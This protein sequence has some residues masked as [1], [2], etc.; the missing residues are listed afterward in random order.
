MPCGSSIG[1]PGWDG[2]LTVPCGNAWIPSGE[3]AL[4]MSCEQRPGPK[5]TKDYEKRT[6]DPLGA[7]IPNTTFVFVTPRR[8]QGKRDWAN[9]RKREGRW[10]DVRVLDAVDLVSWIEQAPKAGEWFDG[11]TG[12]DVLSR[13][14]LLEIKDHQESLHTIS[15][16]EITQHTDDRHSEVMAAIRG[17]GAPLMASAD[18]AEPQA[19]SDPAHVELKAK[20]DSARDSIRRGYVNVARIQLKELR[21]KHDT[22]S[23][24]LEFRILNSLGVCALVDE[25][26]DGACALFDEARRL[27][28]ENPKGI[29][30]AALVAHLRKDRQQAV[31]LAIKARELDPQISQATAVLLREY[32]ETERIEELEKL[33]TSEEWLAQDQHCGAVVSGIRVEQMRFGE[34]AKIC[35]SLIEADPGD[36]ELQLALAECLLS[37]VKAEDLAF[38]YTCDSRALLLEAKTAATRSIELL[39]DT[40]LKAEHR[41]ALVSRAGAEVLLGETV[42]ASQDLDKILLEDPAHVEASFYK[43]LLLV[44][45]GKPAEARPLFDCVWKSGRY[46]DVVLPLADACIAS[47]DPSASVKLL[48]GTITLKCP[49]WMDIDRAEILSQAEKEAGVEGS[50]EKILNAAL[51][52]IPNNSRLLALQSAHF[53]SNGDLEGAEQSLLKALKHSDSSDH[54]QIELRLASLYHSQRRYAEAAKLFDGIVN[55]VASHPLAGTLLLCLIRSKQLRKALDWAR[56]IK[57][58]SSEPPKLALE[59]EVEVLQFV[60]D[61]PATI[62]CLLEICSRNDATSADQVRL[63]SAQFRNGERDMALKTAIGIEPADLRQDPQLLLELAKLKL[64]LGANGHLED[65]YLALRFARDNPSVH[66]AYVAMFLANEKKVARPDSVGPGCAVLLE[67]KLARQWWSILDEGEESLDHYDLSKKDDLAN[68]L[69]GRRAGD[70]VV[71]REDLEELSY[72]VVE[73]QSKYVRAF[74]ETLTEFSTRF[75]SNKELTRIEIRGDD[76]TKVFLSVDQHDNYVREARQQ[77][78]E[79]RLPLVTLCSLLGRSALEVWRGFTEDDSSAVLTGSGTEEEATEA[80]K[81]LRNTDCVVLDIVALF[82]VHK[83]NLADHLQ[84]RFSRVAVSQHVYDAIQNTANMTRILGQPVGYMGKDVDGR[85]T[86]IEVPENMRTEWKKYVASVLETCESFERIPSYKALDTNDIEAHVD[87]LTP[88]GASAVYA[89]E[90]EAKGDSVLISDDLGLSSVAHWIGIGVVNTQAVLQELLDSNMV[91]D[92]EYSAWIE[93]LVSMNYRFVRVAQEDI[94]RRLKAN[95]YVTTVSTRK[96]ISTLEGPDCSLE[97]AVSV[98]S[99][100]IATLVGKTQ[101]SQVGL[102]TMAFLESLQKGRDPAVGLL[103]FRQAL[104]SMLDPRS[105]RNQ[106][107]LNI[108]DMHI[109]LLDEPLAN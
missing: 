66:N 29:A 6:N 41:S 33:V 108:V 59:V 106:D 85:Y 32:W 47:G 89:G 36:F 28:P 30:N 57:D 98:A 58:V 76:F 3:I 24:D 10:A 91:S 68:E 2:L 72:R 73:V 105:P 16:R 43:G 39:Q 67:S 87:A 1:L 80:S 48:K 51:E 4:E 61:V 104:E 92:E 97:S 82:T 84:T 96:M 79:G 78:R 14:R 90:E 15:T 107:V 20:I 46:P 101:T 64:L 71:L 37:W 60:G 99:T 55:G 69:L 21:D 50:V 102:I 100:V 45:E 52:Q 81:L 7:D 70:T 34:A 12:K 38:R 86:L 83:L 94:L 63:A 74:Q 23:V 18:S 35:R 88:A 53:E 5:A 27:Q 109:R 77:Y 26:I 11:V 40:D 44:R 19:A 22:M 95:G 17:L 8:W 54:R 25:C 56:E 65:A 62:S 75:P 93:Q 42:E 9:D 13:D 49:D 31:Q 103:A